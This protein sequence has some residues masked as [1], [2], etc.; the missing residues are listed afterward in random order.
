MECAV[1]NGED[2]SSLGDSNITFLYTLGPGAFPKSFGIN[3]A[4]LAGL[5][6]EVLWNTKRI[7]ADFELETSGEVSQ[8]RALT[9]RIATGLKEKV[10]EALQKTGKRFLLYG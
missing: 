3:V 9:A 4:R 5:P 1:G 6:E 7:S 2:T 10:K 8:R